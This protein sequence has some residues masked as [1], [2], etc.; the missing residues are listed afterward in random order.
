MPSS[1]FLIATNKTSLLLRC[2]VWTAVA[3]DIL[4]QEN[5]S[6]FYLLIF[7]FFYYTTTVGGNTYGRMFVYFKFWRVK[8]C[9]VDLCSCFLYGF[10]D[11]DSYFSTQY[12]CIVFTIKTIL[13]NYLHYV[14]TAILI[15]K[16][17]FISFTPFKTYWL[18]LTWQRIFRW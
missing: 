11:N 2:I 14:M 3:I 12:F 16:F 1:C 7:I 10:V 4:R 13:E 18:V 15:N 17:F 8:L 9:Y 5:S 6:Y